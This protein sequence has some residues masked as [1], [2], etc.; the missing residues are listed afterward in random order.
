ML[1]DVAQLINIGSTHILFDYEVFKTEVFLNHKKIWLIY[2]AKV[3]VQYLS[4]W[5]LYCQ[6]FQVN[7]PTCTL[8]LMVTKIPAWIFCVLTFIKSMIMFLLWNNMLLVLQL[9]GVCKKDSSIAQGLK[10]VIIYLN[11]YQTRSLIPVTR[12]LMWI[13]PKHQI[14]KALPMKFLHRI[15][16]MQI[17]TRNMKISD[18][19]HSNWKKYIFQ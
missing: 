4:H 9:S 1:Q 3:W 10:E 14:W 16:M 6:S 13:H 8:V 18:L 11:H 5:R 2:S 12:W 7:S 19:Y 15:L 17:K